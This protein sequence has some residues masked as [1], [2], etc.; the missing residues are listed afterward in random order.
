MRINGEAAK[1]AK[2]WKCGEGP[3]FYKY[4][5]SSQLNLSNEANEAVHCEADL[6]TSDYV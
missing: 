6:T 5:C 3:T 1:P 2:N 4:K